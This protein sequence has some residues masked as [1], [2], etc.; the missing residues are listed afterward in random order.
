MLRHIKTQGFSDIR[1]AALLRHALNDQDVT[2]NKVRSLLRLAAGG[3]L[4]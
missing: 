1:I 4:K 2:E 3:I